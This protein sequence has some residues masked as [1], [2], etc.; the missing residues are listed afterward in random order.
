MSEL[1]GLL[2]EKIVFRQER[3]LL[4]RNGNA[5]CRNCEDICPV[6]AIE[7]RENKIFYNS[8]KCENCGA[9]RSACPTEA[10]TIESF[11]FL[12]EICGVDGEEV[13]IGCTLNEANR[14]DFNVC[15]Y[16]QLTEG[17]LIY[18]L[19]QKKRLLFFTEHCEICIYKAG[20]QLFRNYVDQVTGILKDKDRILLCQAPIQI[21]GLS[22]RIFFQWI[23]QK[24]FTVLGAALPD[25]PDEAVDRLPGRRINLLRGLKS[26]AI[27]PSEVLFIR[28]VK[29]SFSCTGCGGCVSICP[30]DAF[31][32]ADNKLTWEAKR[33]LNCGLCLETCP[34]K[35]LDYAGQVLIM[36][37]FK[38]IVLQEFQGKQCPDCRSYFKGE[39]DKCLNCLSKNHNLTNS[40]QQNV[41]WEAYK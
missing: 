30:F 34:E 25:L 18:L 7:S 39:G 27:V 28:G 14:K 24:A 38:V 12:R 5:A 35:A 8:L 37:L 13:G 19:S 4:R 23:R 20:Y 3:C 2:K 22:R 31:K 33:C 10:F 11:A 26:N 32:L 17:E 16:S 21:E 41:R 40:F 9:C 36:E 29:A 1:K 6:G 15:C